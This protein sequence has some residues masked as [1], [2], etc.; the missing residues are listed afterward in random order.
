MLFDCK[1]LC[2]TM[3]FCS[4]LLPFAHGR[5]IIQSAP[6]LTRQHLPFAEN[7]HLSFYFYTNLF[8]LTY[9]VYVAMKLGVHSSGMLL[10]VD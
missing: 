9:Y 6:N 10:S 8:I 2:W 1:V 5:S 4:L 3:T 7:L